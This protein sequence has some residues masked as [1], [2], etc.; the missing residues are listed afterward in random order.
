MT[1]ALPAPAVETVGSDVEDES[2]ITR[3]RPRMPQRLTGLLAPGPRSR[4]AAPT[5]SWVWTVRAVAALAAW[6]LLYA[7]ALSG[8]QEHRQQAVLYA[9]FREQLALATAPISGPIGTGEPVA[10]LNIP[11]LGIKDLVAVEGTASGTLRA[12]P[13][14]RRDTVLPGQTG[15]SILY[16]RSATYGAPFGRLREMQT[17]DLIAVTTGEGAFSYKVEDVREAGDPLPTALPS[18]GSRLVLESSAGSSWRSGFAPGHVLYVDALLTGPATPP[19]Q[20]APLAA[21]ER[22]MSSD[23]GGLTTLVLWLEGL[24]LVSLGTVWIGNR[25]GRWQSWIVGAPLI[26]ALLWGATSAAT[27][28]L[29]NLL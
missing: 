20:R 16:G 2:R 17:G 3:L 13:G 21:H 24:L 26:L 9:H 5:P 4:V 25:W 22:A 7:F 11:V 12:G 15:V 6:L 19:G 10:L 18:G 1:I 27:D 8:V 14:H 29:P 23:T 28:L